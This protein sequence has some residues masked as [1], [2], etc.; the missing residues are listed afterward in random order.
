METPGVMV[1]L[2]VGAL[3]RVRVVVRVDVLD[4]VEDRD[5]R[6]GGATRIRG[7]PFA[8]MMNG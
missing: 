2:L 5:G 7:S 8:S 1:D 6:R 4:A 3:L